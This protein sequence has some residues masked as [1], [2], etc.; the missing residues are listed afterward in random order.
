MKDLGPL[1]EP[2]PK[3]L[4]IGSRH[5]ARIYEPKSQQE[6]LVVHDEPIVA[7]ALDRDGVEWAEGEAHTD[8]VVIASLDEEPVVV[9]VELTTTVKVKSRKTVAGKAM[10]DPMERKAR[11]LD[12][13]VAHFHPAARAG[14]S[15]THGDD[16]HDAWT[17]GRD[18]TRIVPTLAHRVGAV[19]IGFHQQARTPLGPTTVGGTTVK[20]AVWSPVPSS[21]NRGQ[22]TLR[23]LA[24]QLGW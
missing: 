22:V 13:V 12:G 7:Y 21:R 8:A 3:P 4:P 2:A 10:V 16:H 18:L 15:R 17:A 1:E 11:Q 6:L 24:R 9:F 23:E 14:A 19:V 5:A 20:R